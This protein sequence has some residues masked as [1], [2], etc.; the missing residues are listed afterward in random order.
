MKKILL[1]AILLIFSYGAYSQT[2]TIDGRVFGLDKKPLSLATVT[3]FSAQDTTIITYRMSDDEGR[4][5]IPNLPLHKELRVLATYSGYEAYRKSFTLTDSVPV[6]HLDSIWMM[7]TSKDLDEV[8]VVSE[9]PPVMMKNDTI[10]FNA[11]AFKTLPNALVEDLLKKLPGVRVDADG[12]ITV[13]GK[14]VNK[15]LVDG[16]AFFGDDPK[17]ATRNLP[18]N[19]IDKVQVVDDKEQALLNGDNNTSNVGK[20][21]NITLKKGF[22]KGAFG[23]LYAGGGTQDRYELGGIVNAFRDTLQVSILGYS[24]NLNRPGFSYGELMNAGGLKRTNSNRNNNSISNW[25]GMNGSTIMVNGVNFGGSPNFGLATSNGAGFNLNHAPNKKRS[26]YLQ[27]YFGQVRKTNLPSDITRIYNRDTIVENTS[28]GDNLTKNYG[29]NLGAGIKLKPDSVTTINFNTSYTIGLQRDNLLT[30]MTSSN[31]L[32]GQQSNGDINQYNINNNYNYNHAFFFIKQGRKDKRKNFIISNSFNAGVKTTDNQTDAVLNYFLPTKYDSTLFQLRNVRLPQ[33]NSVFNINFREPISKYFLLRFNNRYRF[34][35]VGNYVNTKQSLATN[36]D[37]NI[38]VPALSNSFKRTKN[39]VTF[40]QGISFQSKGFTITPNIG[41]LFLFSDLD[42]KTID[43][44]IH[45]NARK[46]VTS[47]DLSYKDFSL[48]YNKDYVLPYYGYLLPVLDNSNPY[49]I[50]NGNPYLGL[51]KQNTID[52]NMNLNDQKRNFNVWMWGSVAFTDND[53]I[54]AV[55]V[56]DQGVQTTAP[57]NA[58]GTRTFRTNYNIDKDI[59][60]SEKNKL[61]LS[62]GGYHEFTHSKMFYNGEESWQTTANF[63]NWSGIHFNFNDLIEWDNSY[64][65]SFNYTRYSS[66]NFKKFNITFQNWSSGLIVRY[67]KHIIWET[68]M[69]YSYNSNLTGVNKNMWRWTAAINFTFLKDERGVLKLMAYDILNQNKRFVD[70]GVSQN[71]WSRSVGS[72][73]PQY[74]MATFTYN[75]RQVGS[76]Q[77]VGGSLFHL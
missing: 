65:P 42:V 57:V 52:V 33:T 41:E 64:N 72:M 59:K 55:T 73:M 76:K 34:D 4:I 30:Q 49:N 3:V 22:K 17:M 68:N 16:K 11:N 61:T 27:Y 69:N 36:G 18:A 48:S 2:G 58:N 45:Q 43:H 1:F 13:N 50:V 23:K 21:V 56:N 7:P 6:L 71:M 62:I 77:K 40:Y 14:P 25:N 32:L 63:N 47:V 24:N 66:S 20:V 67:P 75:I 5:K 37:Y 9:R 8:I 44:T 74:F 39:D 38:F 28:V 12:N 29:H 31:N 46:L 35:Y 26:F 54:Q 10:E 19:A 51:S 53:V 60:L 70:L 15:I